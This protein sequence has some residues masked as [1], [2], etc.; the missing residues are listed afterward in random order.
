[1]K[2]GNPL[3]LKPQNEVLHWQLVASIVTVVH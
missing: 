2:P 1:M 3:I